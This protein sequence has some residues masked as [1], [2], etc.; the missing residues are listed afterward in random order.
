MIFINES[1]TRTNKK[2]FNM[3]RNFKENWKY[4]WMK[5]GQTYLKKLDSDNT[6]KIESIYDLSKYGIPFNHKG[7]SP[8]VGSSSSGTM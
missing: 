6:F 8:A 1:L 5:Q 7:S 2:I 3:C 4:V